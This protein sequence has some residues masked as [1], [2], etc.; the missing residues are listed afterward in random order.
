MLSQDAVLNYLLQKTNGNLSQSNI[1]TR[2]AEELGLT[3]YNLEKDKTGLD[4]KFLRDIVIPYQYTDPQ[5]LPNVAPDDQLSKESHSF[6]RIWSSTFYDLIVKIYQKHCAEMAQI[7]ALKK[8]R[9]VVAYYFLHGVAD[10]PSTSKMF[11]AIARQM[12]AVD[13]V[14][15]RI[16][17]NILLD[18]FHT[19]NIL[20][21]QVLMLK[22]WHI[23][24][25]KKGDRYDNNIVHI[26]NTKMIK[27]CDYIGVSAMDYNPLHYIDIS[28]PLD[29]MHYFDEK[30]KLN[31]SLT[32]DFE[33]TV[34]N[35]LISVNLLHYNNLIGKN[36]PFSIE[37]GKLIRNYI[38]CGCR[39]RVE[40]DPN[41]P[42][43]GK[44]YKPQNNAG[45]CGK[46]KA[47]SCDCD[48]VAPK[49]KP[50]LGCYTNVKV[51]SLTR[52]RNGGNISRKV[53]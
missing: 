2:I 6:S 45:C 44:G 41:S 38:D 37:N 23:S 16:Y 11:E 4:S 12:L 7:D 14:N 29:E 8:A 47:R 3:L 15:G 39:N 34:H 10:V 52:Y 1:V 24:D 35:T 48:P 13:G 53:C 51:G 27:L 20:R 21:D 36:Q 46:G 50:K 43:Y 25:F 32:A 17:R 30:G 5:N 9:D 31:Y 19:H 22:N 28:L 42:E 40:C 49:P 33:E 18:V 26:K